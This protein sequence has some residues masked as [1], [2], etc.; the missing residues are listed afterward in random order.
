MAEWKEIDPYDWEESVF[1]KI[2][3]DWMLVASAKPDGSVNAMT[4]SWGGFGILWGNKV[5]F[6]FIRPT[7]YTKE[8][9][10]ASGRLSLTF[11]DDGKYRQMLGYMGSTSGRDED[12]IKA[13]GLTVKWENGTPYFD[14]AETAVITRVLYAQDLE[15]DDFLD[16]GVRDDCYPDRDYHTMYVC[17]IEKML[18]KD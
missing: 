3:R 8:F 15:G 13:Q 7:R 16:T 5:A 9:V 2:D 17:K 1:K 4:A 6:V 14:E 12:K 11:Y 18:V 10:D